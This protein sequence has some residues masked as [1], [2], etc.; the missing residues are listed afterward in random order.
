MRESPHWQSRIQVTMK[1]L[2]LIAALASLTTPLPA[3][4]RNLELSLRLSQQAMSMN[5]SLAVV[6]TWRNLSG[7]HAVALR[8]EPG[9]SDSGGLEFVVM[10]ANGSNR[11]LTPFRG[12]LSAAEVAAGDRKVDLSPG[13]G[14]GISF[15]LTPRDL[16]PG[17]GRYQVGVRYASPLP[18]SGNPS[19]RAEVL[20]GARAE[21][22][23]YEVEVLP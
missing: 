15:R 19:V 18:S 10:D 1:F 8:G 3:Q 12:R 22:R 13:H 7:D 20:E 14:H 2:P 9:P 5:S 6:V 17:P 23:L 21:S 16:F 4:N 11:A